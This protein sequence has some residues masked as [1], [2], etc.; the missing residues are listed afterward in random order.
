L[1]VYS[2]KKIGDKI[3]WKKALNVV[4][5]V[6]A[7]VLAIIVSFWHSEGLDYIIFISRFF[8]V[9]L[10]ILAVGALLKFLFSH[11]TCCGN[12]SCGKKKDEK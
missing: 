6:I 3:M 2:A 5:A 9:M 1:Q 11:C 4:I 7:L 10:P 8:D 12:C